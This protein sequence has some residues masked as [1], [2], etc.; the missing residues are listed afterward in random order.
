MQSPL[1]ENRSLTPLAAISLHGKS[2]AF[3]L[4]VTEHT[5]KPA[6]IRRE[7]GCDKDTCRWRINDSRG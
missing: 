3:K 5:D 2:E 6:E 4:A 1:S 7:E